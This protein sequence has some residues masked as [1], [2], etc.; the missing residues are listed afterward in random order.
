MS[1]NLTEEKKMDTITQE[2]IDKVVNN[3]KQI[4]VQFDKLDGIVSDLNNCT[5]DYTKTILVSA[6]S[7]LS[8]QLGIK[9]KVFG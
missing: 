4:M 3:F 1:Y 5:S 7:K 8:E 6:I 2:T 9:E